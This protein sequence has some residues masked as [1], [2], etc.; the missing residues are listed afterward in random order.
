MSGV[1]PVAPPRGQRG[2]QC[3][4][5]IGVLPDA[6]CSPETAGSEALRSET[7]PVP[8]QTVGEDAPDGSPGCLRRGEP[9]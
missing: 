9:S 5:V 2:K 4:L 7:E 6:V 3:V 8:N 1:D